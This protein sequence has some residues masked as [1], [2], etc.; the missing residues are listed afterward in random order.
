MSEPF[1][2][3]H[4]VRYSECDAQKIVFNARY[5][6]YIDF[7]MTEFQRAIW[8]SQGELTEHGLENQVVNVNMNWFAPATFDDV[9]A[10]SISVIRIGN[11]SYT[12]QVEFSNH[13][14]GDKLSA[15]EMTSVLVQAPDHQ[16]KS[17]TGDI[18]TQLEAGARDV[19]I[20]HAGV[21]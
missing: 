6:D 19:V 5:I 21:T 2:Y 15:A 11:T 20:D 7:A 1:C 3:L 4:R 10:I 17:I 8:S 13:H 12:V 9:L 16:K 14:T 18:R